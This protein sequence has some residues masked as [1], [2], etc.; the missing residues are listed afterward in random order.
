MKACL[1]PLVVMAV[2]VCGCD[3]QTAK[4]PSGEGPSGQNG[5]EENIDP[6]EKAAAA[7]LTPAKDPVSEEIYAAKLKTRQAYNNRRFDELEQ[8]VAELR[9]IKEV[10]GNGS[11]KIVQFYEALGCSDDEPASMWQLHD[12]IHQEWIEARPESIA[13]RVAYAEFLTD[14]AW[15]ARGTEFASG[16][17]EEGWKL[18]HERLAQS[19]QI[20]EE[21]RGLEQKDPYW[22]MT[23]LTVALGQNWDAAQVEVLLAEARA[24]EP[25]FWGYDVSRAYSLLPRWHGEPGD[26]EKFA[27][28]ASARPEGLGSETYARIVIRLRGFYANVFRESAAKWPQTRE[29]LTILLQKYPDSLGLLSEAAMLATMAEDRA[30]AKELFDRIGDRYLPSTWRK[31]ERFTHFRNWAATGRW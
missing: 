22:W 31:P 27:A 26:W 25:K 3:L 18:F 23:A 12:R 24:F 11:W 1:L 20:L 16:V 7:Q 14:Y 2:L 5:G 8:E 19:R 28:A 13:A 10:F 15:L 4:A 9:A 21:A 30:L 17:K 6:G 29:G